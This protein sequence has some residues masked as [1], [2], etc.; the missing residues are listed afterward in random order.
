MA[1]G[2]G[3]C[4]IALAKAEEC[5]LTFKAAG[6]MHQRQ[7]GTRVDTNLVLNA[8]TFYSAKRIR[9]FLL[10]PVIA[11]DDSNAEEINGALLVELRSHDQ[12]LTV[13]TNC[14]EIGIDDHFSE[15]AY[16]GN[17]SKVLV[18]MHIAVNR[19]LIE[20]SSSSPTTVHSFSEE[21]YIPEMKRFINKT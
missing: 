16:A 13:I 5:S 1:R 12:N 17:A 11:G 7:I 3:S 6:I 14:A 19:R 9:D 15:A 2:D 21:C 4:L 8:Q 10:Q 18:A 20:N